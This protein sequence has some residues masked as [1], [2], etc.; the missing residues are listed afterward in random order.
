MLVLL[1]VARVFHH[2]PGPARRTR[3]RTAEAPGQ[4]IQSIGQAAIGGLP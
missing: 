1:A 4:I 2:V 3:G